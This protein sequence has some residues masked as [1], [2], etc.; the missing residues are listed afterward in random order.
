MI[1]KDLIPYSCYGSIATISSE[2]SLNK[3]K[4]FLSINR[5][6]IECFE[7]VIIS[8]NSADDVTT[9]IV[10]AYKEEWLKIAP[11]AIILYS[12]SNAGHMFGTIDLEEAIL[13]YIKANL[14]N[15]QYL[16]KTMDDVIT[17]VSMFDL[18]LPEAGF[19]YLPSISYESLMQGEEFVPQTTFFILSLANVSSLYGKDVKNKRNTYLKARK[20]NPNL[21]PWEMSYD[22]KFDCETHLQ[23][24]VKDIT[25]KCLLDDKTYEKL[26]NF[27]RQYKLGDPSHKNIFFTKQG[28]CHYHMW[29]DTVFEL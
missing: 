26:L 21:K 23:R 28:I 8:L 15:T 4:F 16:F 12:R 13:T 9:D 2:E 29:Q 19:Y 24:T 11:K 27:V 3:V 17:N 25:K 6:F 20:D 5:P 1:L 18:D 14:P 10:A 7:N 22:I